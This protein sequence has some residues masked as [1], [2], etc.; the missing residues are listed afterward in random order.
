VAFEWPI[1][2]SAILAPSAIGRTQDIATTRRRLFDALLA[3]ALASA[4]DRE[5]VAELTGK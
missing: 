5:L 3:E 1:H 2:I 4:E